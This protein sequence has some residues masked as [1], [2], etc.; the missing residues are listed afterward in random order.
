M[1]AGRYIILMIY[2]GIQHRAQTEDL[3]RRK[4]LK[5]RTAVIDTL[6]GPNGF[7]FER[8]GGR[9]VDMHTAA[10]GNRVF[11]KMEDRVRGGEPVELRPVHD[12]GRG[13]GMGIGVGER[14]GNLL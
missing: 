11:E 4:A 12:Y 8:N 2:L 13:S 10:W 14:R 1:D 5:N 3:A 6:A 7:H 9:N